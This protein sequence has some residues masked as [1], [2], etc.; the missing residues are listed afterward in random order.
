MTSL[1]GNLALGLLKAYSRVAPTERG[2]FRL[3]R[4]ARRLVP[5]R[6]WERDFVTPD[7][8]TLRLDLGTYPDCCMA[9]GLYELDT[10]R[11]L[12]RLL[13]PGSWFVDVG[14]NIGYFSILAA[15]WTGP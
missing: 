5:R 12:R 11:L 9:V 2:G 14:A 15:R 8:T 10:Y 4:L 6:H 13:R 1:P 3:A 7:R